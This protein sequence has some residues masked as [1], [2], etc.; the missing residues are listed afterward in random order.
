A[1]PPAAAETEVRQKLRES[2]RNE[3][4]PFAAAGPDLV[5]IEAQAFDAP[6]SPGEKLFARHN[7]GEFGLDVASRLEMEDYLLRFSTQGRAIAAGDVH[8]D[9]WEDIAITLDH[10]EGGFALF[11]NAGGQGFIRQPVHL[12]DLSEQMIRPVSFAD[13][14]GDGWLDLVFSTYSRGLYVIYNAEG[15][16]SAAPELIHDPGLGRVDNITF[17]DLDRNGTLDIAMGVYLTAWPKHPEEPKASRNG[18]LLQRSPGQFDYVAL[19][20]PPGITHTSLFSDFDQDGDVDLITGDDFGPADVY[21]LN[22]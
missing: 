12:S 18:L 1:S 13:L 11:A 16:F 20:G 22:D 4:T 5:T 10:A 19:S 2:A 15:S 9:G 8:N 7:G 6:S 3:W 14:N 17:A 21:Y